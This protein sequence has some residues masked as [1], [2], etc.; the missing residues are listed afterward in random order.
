MSA[1]H[2]RTIPE[3]CVFDR[4]VYVPPVPSPF[5]DIFFPHYG[6]QSRPVWRVACGAYVKAGE[7]VC[8][9]GTRWLFGS[10]SFPITC[11]VN[12]LLVSTGSL[13]GGY[14]KDASWERPLPATIAN[15]SMAILVSRN[16]P[17]PQTDDGSFGALLD[18]TSKHRR[19]LF[20]DKYLSDHMRGW[21]TDGT[22]DRFLDSVRS[23][24]LATTRLLDFW[25]NVLSDS[26]CSVLDVHMVAREVERAVRSS[27]ANFSPMTHEQFRSG[28]VESFDCHF[29]PDA[30]IHPDRDLRTKVWKAYRRHIADFMGPDEFQTDLNADAR[31]TE[32]ERRNVLWCG[33]V[34]EHELLMYRK[35]VETLQGN[36]QI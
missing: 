2:E 9:F 17:V 23:R 7:E 32:E 28:K 11:P 5:D 29:H 26:P 24:R 34:F 36:R 21:L 25:P 1:D 15:H 16:G 33:V 30:G 12:G 22:L 8:G 19:K 13:N 14:G 18:L 3:G 4:I 35:S 10:V 6:S 31:F 27:P 20:T